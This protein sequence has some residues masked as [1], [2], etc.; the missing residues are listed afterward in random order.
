ML[1]CGAEA[2]EV[3]DILSGAPQDDDDDDN[4]VDLAQFINMVSGYKA[5]AMELAQL[6]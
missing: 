1:S 2:Q 3:D 6:S 4:E 5:S